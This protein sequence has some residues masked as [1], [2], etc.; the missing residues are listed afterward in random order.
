MPLAKSLY[1][2][3]APG[4]IFWI[5]MTRIQKIVPIDAPLTFVCVKAREDFEG[6]ILWAMYWSPGFANPQA[7]ANYG[8]KVLGKD[9]I[10]S[11]C[12]CDD[13][14]MALYRY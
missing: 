6:R 7:V 3:I 5:V 8:H 14:I 2:Q 4:E 13:E 9:T 11:V 12:P 1:D 10:Q